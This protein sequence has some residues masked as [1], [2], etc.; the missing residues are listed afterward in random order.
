MVIIKIV[1]SSQP[2]S[3][4]FPSA[5]QSFTGKKSKSGVIL[6]F[7]C[8]LGA[9]CLAQACNLSTEEAK[10][11]DHCKVERQPGLWNSKFQVSQCY[12]E[13]PCLQKQIKIR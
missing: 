10:Q 8:S 5:E 6:I 4:I 2:P 9:K 11:K 1:S 13:R 12:M 7:K 3:I